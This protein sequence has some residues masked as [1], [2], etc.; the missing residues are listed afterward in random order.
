VFAAFTVLPEVREC[1]T[2]THCLLEMNAPERGAD[3]AH[4][5]MGRLTYEAPTPEYTHKH[6]QTHN[7]ARQSAVRTHAVAAPSLGNRRKTVKANMLAKGTKRCAAIMRLYAATAVTGMQPP[8]TALCA[9]ARFI[10]AECDAQCRQ[11]RRQ[12]GWPPGWPRGRCVSRI[13][14]GMVA[15]HWTAEHSPR[16]VSAIAE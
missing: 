12:R 8:S 2:K 6:T 11:R 5:Q 7:A 16:A 13:A 4:T 3:T 15:E 10:H 1:S 14:Q 9:L